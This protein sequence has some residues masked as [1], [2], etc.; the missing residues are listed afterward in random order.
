MIKACNCPDNSPSAVFQSKEY[1]KGMRLW[2]KNNRGEAN[3][4]T[5]C[6]NTGN[7]TGKKK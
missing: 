4:C 3:R 5:I 6:G 7:G 1:G 2:T